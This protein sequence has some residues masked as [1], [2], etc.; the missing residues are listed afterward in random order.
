MLKLH[1]VREVVIDGKQV[2]LMKIGAL[3]CDL[4][5]DDSQLIMRN[6]EVLDAFLKGTR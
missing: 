5:S 2:K 4:N 3:A 1:N 6:R